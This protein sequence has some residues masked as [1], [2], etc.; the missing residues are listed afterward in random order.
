MGTKRGLGIL[1]ACALTVTIIV[2]AVLPM[3]ASAAEA[4]TAHTH[5]WVDITKTV[6][7]DAVTKKIHHD[8]VTKI[9]H[10]PAE[11]MTEHHDAITKI[12]HHDAVYETVTV[13]EQGHWEE[14][15]TKVEVEPA[16]DEQ[17]QELHTFCNTCGKDLSAAG[18]SGDNIVLHADECDMTGW[19]DNLVVVQTIHHDAI[20]EDQT[21]KTWIVDVPAHDEQKLVSEAWDETVVVAP[22]WDETITTKAPWDET[23]VVTPAWDETVIVTPAYDEKIV[24]GCECSICHEKLASKPNANT[25]Q[26]LKTV[27]SDVTADGY[28]VT[29]SFAAGAGVSSVKMPSWT[30][31]KVNGTDQDDLIWHNAQISGDTATFYVK[32]SDHKNESGAYLTHVYVFDKKGRST[33]AGVSVNVPVKPVTKPVINSVDISNVTSSGYQ[34][35]V[36]FT[37]AAGVKSLLLPT[38]TAKKVNGTDQDD[39]IW[40]NASISGNTGTF[41]VKTSDHKNES[42]AYITHV[43]LTDKNGKQ[44]DVVGKTVTVPVKQTTQQQTTQKYVYGGVDYSAVFE[45][46]YYLSK[47]AD[48]K[49]AFGSNATAALQ[50]FVNFGM[51]EGRQAISTFN[52]HT[53]RAR[54]TD[55][56]K[57]FGSNLKAYYQHYMN[58]GIKEGRKAY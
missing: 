17:I 7:H 45:P 54:Y 11:T 56:Q 14:T 53:Y 22:A 42:G 29:T 15:T 43:Y 18:L 26:I 8:A 39:L 36:K 27:V 20:Y 33:I 46:N 19:H 38:W 50:H 21:T 44:A 16:W 6:H 30:A 2:L 47:Y 58:F 9:V 3:N 24:T 10:H 28:R 52:V 37:A 1:I 34:V 55:L 12:I 48:L 35:T 13:P 41:Y 57:A 31:K 4:I 25:L 32:T 49:A 51:S 23:V 5:K 40:H